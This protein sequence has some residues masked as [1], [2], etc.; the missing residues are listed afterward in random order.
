MPPRDRDT[1][2]QVYDRIANITPT[3]TTAGA[4]ARDCITEEMI[5]QIQEIVNN[6]TFPAFSEITLSDHTHPPYFTDK[7]FS[8]NP[9]GIPEETTIENSEE[10]DTF[11]K[12]FELKEVC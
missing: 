5:R 8:E 9:K 10:L 7:L 3:R 11:L 12:E 4:I 1:M 2:T 6:M